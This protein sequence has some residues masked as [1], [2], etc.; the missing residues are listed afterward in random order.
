M[1]IIRSIL[2]FPLH[3]LK[4][5]GGVEVVH[6]LYLLSILRSAKVVLGNLNY[7]RRE[8]DNAYKV[9]DHHKAVEGIRDVPS[10]RGGKHCAEDNGAD[11]DDTEDIGGLCAEEIFPSLG[12]V[13]GPAQ[14]GG[15]GKEEHGDSHELLTD[16][17]PGEYGVKCACN[18][19]R[20]GVAL[21][22]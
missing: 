5:D 3:F 2:V 1:T 8:G 19:S 13:V 16:I 22:G 18:Q 15:K 17:A 9:G 14:N 11:V 10:Q 7:Q 21:C 6:R 4:P 20:I 12:A